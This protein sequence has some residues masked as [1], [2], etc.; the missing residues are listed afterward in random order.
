VSSELFQEYRGILK[1]DGVVAAAKVEKENIKKLSVITGGTAVWKKIRGGSMVLSEILLH[2]E[3]ARFGDYL[4]A[5]DQNTFLVCPK[6]L[7]ERRFSYKG[8]LRD[9]VV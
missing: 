1:R 3:H 7:F 8:P 5:L 2:G 4:I 6:E 9:P